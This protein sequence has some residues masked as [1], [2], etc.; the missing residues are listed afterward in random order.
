MAREKIE[1]KERMKIPRQP[2]PA[3]EP[4][5][6][7]KNFSEVALGFTE[8]LALVE[9]D[10]CLECKKPKCVDGCPVG[11]DIPG[12]IVAIQQA[13]FEG[14]LAIIKKDNTLPAICGRVWS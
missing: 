10:R 12:F 4:L 8:E 5:D 7:I 6:R 13:D 3:Q 1:K 2:M 11:I 9:A 14:A